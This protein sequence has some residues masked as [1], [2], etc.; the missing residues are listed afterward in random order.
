MGERSG[1]E[2]GKWRHKKNEVGDKMKGGGLTSVVYASSRTRPV[3]VPLCACS[4]LTEA[5]MADRKGAAVQNVL[6]EGESM[7]HPS[8]TQ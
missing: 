4:G 8:P 6:I 3:T 5:E 7:S 2:I 1:G